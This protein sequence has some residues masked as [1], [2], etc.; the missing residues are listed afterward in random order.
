LKMAVWPFVTPTHVV[1]R[2]AVAARRGVSLLWDCGNAKFI[3]ENQKSS[4]NL[5]DTGN[6]SVILLSTVGSRKVF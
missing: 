4:K 1:G 3:G 6:G 2:P 5:I